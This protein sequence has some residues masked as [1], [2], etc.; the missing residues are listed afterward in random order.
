M[1]YI[2]IIYLFLASYIFA[3]VEI[4]IEGGDGWAKKLPTWKLPEGHII[5]KIFFGGRTVT[6]YHVW[7]NIFI[8]FILHSVYLFVPLQFSIETKILAFYMLFWVIEDFLWF[9]INPSYGL[10]NFKKE[11][12]W[13]H[14]KRWFVFAPIEYFIFVPIAIILYLL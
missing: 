2:F 12:I 11:K 14:E 9:V 5:S 7:V 1:H 8:I 3:K 10:K 4:A 13:W 6:G